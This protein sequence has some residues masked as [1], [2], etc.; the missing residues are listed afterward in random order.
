MDS[1]STEGG[2][3]AFITTAAISFVSVGAL[4][5]CWPLVAH[6]APNPSSTPNFID[7]DLATVAPRQ[8]KLAKWQAE[9]LLIRRWTA[10]S[11]WIVTQ[12]NCS[13]CAC[14][15]KRLEPFAALP[16]LEA[17]FCPCCASRFEFEGH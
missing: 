6:L 2:R 17:F 13:H 4:L 10:H 8:V 1:N 11:P 16:S 12:G 7:I 3:R 15:L 9:P 14:V 5:A